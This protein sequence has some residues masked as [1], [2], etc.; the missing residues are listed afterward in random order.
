MNYDKIAETLDKAAFQKQLTKQISGYRPLNLDEAYAVQA[1]SIGRRLLRGE[2]MVGIKLGFTSKAKMEQMGVHD[3]IW[4]RLTSQMAIKNE[5]ST[6]MSSYLH[7]RAEPEIAFRLKT[8]ILEEK[9]LDNI[10]ECVESVAVAIEII[11]S[12]YENFKFSLEDVIADNCSSS[13]YCLGA[14]YPSY[15]F[16]D[17]IDITL[18]V[19]GEVSKSGRTSAI[20]GNPW[21]SMVAATRL[22]ME[23][24]IELKAGHVILAGAATAAVYIE[25]GQTISAEAEGLGKVSFDVKK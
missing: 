15:M 8:D 12:R 20:L 21:E 14:W 9:N 13:G 4:G 2:E 17:D 18:S 3:M 1:I 5:D 11:D 25:K 16:I 10:K 23:Y 22:A 19:D 24:G 7:P 6:E